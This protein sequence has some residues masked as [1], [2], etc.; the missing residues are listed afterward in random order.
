MDPSDRSTSASCLTDPYFEGLEVTQEPVKSVIGVAPQGSVHGQ[1]ATQSSIS[2]RSV[3]NASGN[4]PP[5]GQKNTVPTVKIGHNQVQK[6]NH[7]LPSVEPHRG[8]G[9]ATNQI[10]PSPYKFD[11]S[12]NVSH[13][14]NIGSMVIPTHSHAIYDNVDNSHKKNGMIIDNEHLEDIPN[15]QMFDGQGKNMKTELDKEVERERERQR[16]KE[17]RA[18][19]EF[20][21]KLPIKQKRRSRETASVDQENDRNNVHK[22]DNSFNFDLTNHSLKFPSTHSQHYDESNDLNNAGRQKNIMKAMNYK[23]IAKRKLIKIDNSDNKHQ[24]TFYY[25]IK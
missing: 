13:M 15:G 23:M 3:A 25:F 1:E 12:D 9:F 16:E 4:W 18:F 21:T 11:A 7:L 22:N 8:S 17:I 10:S 14:V 2:P 24:E 5:I 19:K 20:S 6:N